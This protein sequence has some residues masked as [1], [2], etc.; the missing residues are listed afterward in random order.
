M[1]YLVGRNV[2]YDAISV[3][4]GIIIGFNKYVIKVIKGL[5][6]TAGAYN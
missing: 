5:L 3:C 2:V 1:Y 4:A 6:I